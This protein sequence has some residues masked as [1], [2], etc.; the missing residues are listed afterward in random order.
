MLF[1]VIV[2]HPDRDISFIYKILRLGL[3]VLLL[4]HC[5]ATLMGSI[6]KSFFLIKKKRK[7]EKKRKKVYDLYL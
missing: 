7:K 2:L 3:P 4:L 5:Y 1:V 6:P